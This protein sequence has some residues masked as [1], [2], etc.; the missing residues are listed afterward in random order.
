[1]TLG[2]QRIASAIPGES[3]TIAGLRRAFADLIDRVNELKISDP[4][5]ARIRSIAL[6][7]IESASHWA[8][9]AAARAEAAKTGGE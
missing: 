9:K 3:E 8:I 2:E 4:G 5:T 6:T 7:E 1:M